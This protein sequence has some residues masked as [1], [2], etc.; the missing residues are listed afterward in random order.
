MET[1]ST[2]S[3]IVMIDDPKISGNL[4]EFLNQIQGGLIQGSATS[5]LAIP[6]GSV[7]MTSN[8]REGK[9]Y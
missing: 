5:G 4:S 8:D 2:S 6:K 1:L 9:R 7:L 3:L